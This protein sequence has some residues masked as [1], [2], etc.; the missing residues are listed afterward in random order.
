MTDAFYCS[1]KCQLSHWPEHKKTCEPPDKQLSRQTK[2][3]EQTVNGFVNRYYYEIVC[4]MIRKMRMDN[5]DKKELILEL[6]FY[7]A[8]AP[9]LKERPEFKVG[10]ARRYFEGSRPDEPDWFGKGT[11]FYEENIEGWLAA[12]RDQ[13]ND[14]TPN[15]LLVLAREPGGNSGMYSVNLVSDETTMTPLFSDEAV[16]AFERAVMYGDDSRLAGIYNERL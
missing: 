2:C 15:H 16:D 11:D 9:A 3:S 7:G 4:A 8:S 5:M 6:D 14:T 13:Y 10:M 1:K 12:L